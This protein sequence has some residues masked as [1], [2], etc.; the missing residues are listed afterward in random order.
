MVARSAGFGLPCGLRDGAALGEV[1]LVGLAA[2]ACGAGPPPNDRSGIRTGPPA[3]AQATATTP[4]KH[5]TASSAVRPRP[6]TGTMYARESSAQ[7]VVVS[8]RHAST[9][10][11]RSPGSR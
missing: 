10:W 3:V 7:G 2:G 5:A 4:R 11:I 1:V 8:S 9:G 6:I